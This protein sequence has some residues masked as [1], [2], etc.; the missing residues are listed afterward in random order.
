MKNKKLELAV[1]MFTGKLLMVM[2]CAGAIVTMVF[3]KIAGRVGSGVVFG[4]MQTLG[5][6][7]FIA[8]GLFGAYSDS[9]LNETIKPLIEDAYGKV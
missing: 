1:F 2:G 5:I 3:D 4:P 6:I 8:V 9:Y 7:V